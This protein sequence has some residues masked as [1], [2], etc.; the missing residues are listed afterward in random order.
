MSP[1]P[2]VRRLCRP[3]WL[4]VGGVTLAAAAA[5]TEAFARVRS[6]PVLTTFQHALVHSLPRVGSRGR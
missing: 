3:Y 5:V 4:R 2:A 1:P 6:A